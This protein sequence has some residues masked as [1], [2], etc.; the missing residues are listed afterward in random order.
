MSTD[1]ILT[2]L[3]ENFEKYLH[4]NYVQSRSDPEEQ[5]FQSKYKARLILESQLKQLSSSTQNNNL[6]D[7]LSPS[8]RV[9]LLD[10]SSSTFMHSLESRH[11]NATYRHFLKVLNSI[12]E[13]KYETNAHQFLIVKLFEFNLAKNHVETEEID[14][15]EKMLAKLVLQLEDL[16]LNASLEQV[17]NPLV[18]NLKLNCF[19]ELIIIWS[20]RADFNKC[21][22]ILEE[23]NEAYAIYKQESLRN[24]VQDD[25]ELKKSD[26]FVTMPFDSVE[27]IEVD[28]ELTNEARKL[29]FE[30]IYTHSLFYSAQI[31]GKLNE[32]EKSAYFCQLTLQRQID[33]HNTKLAEANHETTDENEKKNSKKSLTL[34]SMELQE[35][36]SFNPLDWATHAA[37]LSQ[38]YVCEHDFATARH[39][40]CCA[41][42]ILNKL[43]AD[44]SSKAG[45]I[46]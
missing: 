12:C 2:S 16:T 11:L 43:T 44:A 37:A 20:S 27:L 41:D 34:F 1:Q 5:P 14:A 45:W 21:I 33:Q 3:K 18:F 40:L 32:K 46:F 19:M 25:A 4:L 8:I 42:S 9:D 38:F 29:S 6:N 24:Y 13:Q 26:S 28:M 39:C 17:Y 7:S 15:G 30:S 23:V 31:Y 22:K 10:N 36:I 35:K